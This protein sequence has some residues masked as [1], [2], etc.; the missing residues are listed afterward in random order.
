M[1]DLSQ[2]LQKRSVTIAG[3]RTSLSLEGAFWSALKS[4]AKAQ[5]MP[6]K[7]LIETIDRGRS[8]NLSS[9]VRVYLLT[10]AA[11]RQEKA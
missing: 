7:A 9:A 6:V 3:H 8:G 11:R 1:S 2:K 10:C 4:E 5:G